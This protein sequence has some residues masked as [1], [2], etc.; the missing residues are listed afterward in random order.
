MSELMISVITP[1]F[2][3]GEFIEENILSVLA[4]KYKNFEH[5]IVDGGSKDN[6]LEILNKYK[7]LKWTSRKDKGQSDALNKGFKRARGDII[8]WLN[9]DDTLCKGCFNA[10]N[11]FFQK[12]PQAMIVSG[13]LNRIDK[14]GRKYRKDPPRKIDSDYLLNRLGSVQQ[15][16]TFFR[17]SLFKEVG[18]IDES[19]H[20]AM[21]HDFF[22]RI[23]L[24][25]HRHYTINKQLANFRMYPDTKTNNNNGAFWREKLKINRK[26]GGDLVNKYKIYAWYRLYIA[27][28]L[29]NI[30]P[31]YWIYLRLKPLFIRSNNEVCA[32]G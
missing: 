16:S 31:I 8:C 32:H 25:G 10:I 20:F 21:D 3:Q 22:L 23:L 17:R 6:T 18:Y 28:P 19:L 7:H 11:H 30:K 9:S 27:P 13:G 1:S 4:Q 12:H 29:K 14:K 15:Q 24:K 26:Y 5:I 2:N